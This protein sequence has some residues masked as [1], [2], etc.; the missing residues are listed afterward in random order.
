MICGYAR[1]STD[2]Q[3]TDL[4]AATLTAAGCSVVRC[5]NGKSG[6]STNGRH[7]LDTLMQFLREGD[8][9]MVTRIDRLARSIRDLQNMVHDLRQ[10]GIILRATEQ[11]IDTSTAAGK[12]F[13]DMLGVFAEFE[14]N[15]RRERQA[16]GIAA[17]KVD[18]V[19][20]GR[21]PSIDPA[22]VRQMQ[23]E[24]MGVTVIAKNLGISR[25]SVYRALA[26]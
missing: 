25:T 4:Q 19:Y 3:S 22:K 6:T 2:E 9:L 23:A 14:T 5:D 10:R 20:K 16:E 17:A 21:K 15:L 8:T 11:P 18:G 26:A 7:E 24:G 1:C 12:C 13:L